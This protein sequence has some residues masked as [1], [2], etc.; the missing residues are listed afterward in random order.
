MSDG[1]IVEDG[2]PGELL[3]EGTGEYAALARAWTESLI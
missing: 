3:A 1:Q 2:T